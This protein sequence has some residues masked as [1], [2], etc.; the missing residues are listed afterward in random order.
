MLASCALELERL[1]PACWAHATSPCSEP[2]VEASAAVICR[3]HGAELAPLAQALLDLDN[4]MREVE[5]LREVRKGLQKAW[6]PVRLTVDGAS[7]E[8]AVLKLALD[9]GAQHL[10]EGWQPP[11]W[12]PAAVFGRHALP[13]GCG[14]ALVAR[15]GD[16]IFDSD[17]TGFT[18][19]K[20]DRS[21][22]Y[23]TAVLQ[24]REG[25]KLLCTWE[26]PIAALGTLHIGN[27]RYEAGEDTL[28]HPR[29]VSFK[30]REVDLGV[31]LDFDW[32]S[33]WSISKY[34]NVAKLR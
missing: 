7:I 10:L 32:T 27:Q 21:G 3:K 6:T 2:P 18:L 15:L 14:V 19:A 12:L 29:R 4:A 26:K 23:E 5:R 31:S 1:T 28:F 22:R 30:N 13:A 24:L 16:S 11:A 8:R 25:W 33:R 9:F 20:S 17:R 34:P